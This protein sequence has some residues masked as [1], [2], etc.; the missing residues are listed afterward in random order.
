MTLQADAGRE[1]VD[2]CIVALERAIASTDAARPEGRTPMP[3][4]AIAREGDR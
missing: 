2:D 4:D 3:H 1:M